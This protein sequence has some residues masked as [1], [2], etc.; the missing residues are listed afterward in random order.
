MLNYAELTV[1]SYRMVYHEFKSHLEV[2]KIKCRL[3]TFPITPNLLYWD[4]IKNDDKQL[5]GTV[6][7]YKVKMDYVDKK[8]YT[9]LAY[10][11]L[12]LH[13]LKFLLK[14]VKYSNKYKFYVRC[15]QPLERVFNWLY[16]N[17]TVTL[18]SECFVF[19]FSMLFKILPRYLH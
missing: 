12:S 1:T 4:I 5:K 6:I 14:I 15:S 16:S 19:P 11:W 17:E 10:R 9:H 18:Q 2:I 13:T 7:T 3:C 8:S